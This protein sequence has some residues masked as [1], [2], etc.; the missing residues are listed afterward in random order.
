MNSPVCN[1]YEGEEAVLATMHGKE[2]VIAPL[3][4]RQ[5]GLRVTLASGLDTDRFGTFTREVERTGSQLDAARAK[6]KAAFELAPETRFAIASEGSFGPHPYIPLLP[7]ER[8]IVVM[9]DRRTGFEIIGHDASLETN[10]AHAVVVTPGEALRFAER[11]GFPDHRVIVMGCKDGEPAPTLGL[12]KG[13]VLAADLERAVEATVARCGAAF[14][15]TDMRAHFNPRR[16][17]AIE[18][19]TEDLIR[20][21]RSQCPICARRGFD[22]TE[23]I[24]G[25]PCECCAQPTQVIRMEV[26][27]CAGCG[28]RQER[29]ATDRTSADPGSCS[30]CNP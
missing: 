12:I 20:R 14:V 21:F 15:E 6:I 25:L 26:L 24:P 7:L 2:R 3:L 22:V 13:I 27:T 19:A 29:P 10:F 18:R 17:Q 16:M 5:L 1:V 8:E 4:L 11:T 28:H 30:V 9:V 23:R